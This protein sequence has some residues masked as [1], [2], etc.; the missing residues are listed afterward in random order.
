MDIKDIKSA[1]NFALH[2]YENEVYCMKT[3]E[4]NSFEEFLKHIKEGFCKGVQFTVKAKIGE[5]L[6]DYDEFIKILRNNN[7]L[8]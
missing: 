1:N 5:N 8:Y 2:F 3:T 7:L 4:C 6:I